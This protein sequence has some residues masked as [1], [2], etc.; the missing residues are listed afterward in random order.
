ML[1]E[2]DILSFNNLEMVRIIGV[3]VVWVIEIEGEEALNIEVVVVKCQSERTE[4]SISVEEG[5]ITEM[6]ITFNRD[7]KEGVL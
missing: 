4:A 7:M 2:Q 6:I 3:E 5:N 1:E